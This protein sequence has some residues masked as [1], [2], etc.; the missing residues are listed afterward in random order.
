MK[1]K[2]RY[3]KT[4]DALK[5][6]NTQLRILKRGGHS[7]DVSFNEWLEMETFEDFL[8]SEDFIIGILSRIRQ[9]H[10][11]PRGMSCPICGGN[12]TKIISTLFTKFV[13][14]DCKAV[15]HFIDEHKD[16]ILEPS[17][18]FARRLTNKGKL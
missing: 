13:C 9:N 1:N 12:H 3:T 14:D 11:T 17:E 8:K 6:Y 4:E 16:P 15:V 18:N 5:E 7:V 2:E 10:T